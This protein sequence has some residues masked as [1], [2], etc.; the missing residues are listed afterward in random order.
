MILEFA[1]RYSN[2]KTRYHYAAE[3]GDLFRLTAR[4]HPSEL[5]EADCLRWC[6]S[7][8]RPLADNSVR[9]RLSPVTTFLRWCVREGHAEPA[10]VDALSDRDNPLRRVPRLYGKVQAKHA[11]RWLTHDEAFGQLLITCRGAGQIGMRD[12]LVLRLGLSGLRAAEIIA[13]SLGDLELDHRPPQISWTGQGR[14]SRRIVP[15]P[16]LLALLA[17][18]LRA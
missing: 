5:S 14:R 13:L 9:N 10:L 2:P 8:G 1:D 18:Y 7:I 6:A 16:D 17:R 3:L 11:A 4:R 12:E 15:G